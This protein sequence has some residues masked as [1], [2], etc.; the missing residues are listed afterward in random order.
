MPFL[1]AFKDNVKAGLR[2]RFRFSGTGGQGGYGG[3]GW[4]W[5]QGLVGGSSYDYRKEAGNLFENSIVLT[6]LNWVNRNAPDAPCILMQKSAEDKWEKAPDD[7]GLCDL[8]DYGN[9]DYDGSVLANGTYLSW[10]M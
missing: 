3:N 4:G 2:S 9:K 8:L 5:L 6:G 7:H 1:K 10:F